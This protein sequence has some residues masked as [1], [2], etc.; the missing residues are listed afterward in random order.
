MINIFSIFELY[1]KDG[2][3]L[4]VKLLE[5]RLTFAIFLILFDLVFQVV[6]RQYN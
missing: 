4:E 2:F 1:A 6:Q 3:E 5:N